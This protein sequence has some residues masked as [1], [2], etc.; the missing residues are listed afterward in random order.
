MGGFV[1]KCMQH[2]AREQ[3]RNNTWPC[4]SGKAIFLLMLN[5]SLMTPQSDFYK[6][7]SEFLEKLFE[8][9]KTF[10]KVLFKEWRQG[11]IKGGVSREDADYDTTRAVQNFEGTP[12]MLWKK[13][14]KEK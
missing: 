10:E 4:V 1:F 7:N 3:G 2:Y 14:V 5:I 12:K 11:N 13:I 8:S 9:F 6:K